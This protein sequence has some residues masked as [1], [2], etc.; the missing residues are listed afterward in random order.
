MTHLTYPVDGSGRIERSMAGWAP[1]T[2]PLMDAMTAEFTTLREEIGRH[3]D[4]QRDLLN[5]TFLAVAAMFSVAG[6]AL[7]SDDRTVRL[8]TTFALLFFPW[9]FVML[10][11]LYADRTIRL[12][13]CADY[14]HNILGERARAIL[15]SADVWQWERYKQAIHNGEIP[16]VRGQPR[17]LARLVDGLRWIIF[18]GAGA[19]ATLLFLVISSARYEGPGTGIVL[20]LPL[21]VA[22]LVGLLPVAIVIRVFASLQETSGV[23][24]DEPLLPFVVVPVGGSQGSD[25]RRGVAGATDAGSTDPRSEVPAESAPSAVPLTPARGTAE[26]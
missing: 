1:A 22:L 15:G 24:R 23:V 13:A 2:R 10:A 17:V 11:C 26:L 21:W 25:R 20:D 5:Q 12:L 18:A 4:H 3:Q 14:I 8:A 7:A 6:A 16:C 9:A 19:I